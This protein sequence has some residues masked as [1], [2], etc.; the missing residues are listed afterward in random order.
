MVQG[1]QQ[2][3]R[4]PDVENADAD[5]EEGLED[6]FS[7]M[8]AE[9]SPPLTAARKLEAERGDESRATGSSREDA[10]VPPP[11]RISVHSVRPVPVPGAPEEM[12]Q[13][14][15]EKNSS[16]PLK[17]QD[18]SLPATLA[19]GMERELAR[20][21][22]ALLR[23]NAKLCAGD[24]GGREYFLEL[25]ELYRDN[26]ECHRW[27]DCVSDL[28]RNTSPELRVKA[29]AVLKHVA[30]CRDAVMAA[31]FLAANEM[32]V[33]G[34]TVALRAHLKWQ[35]DVMDPLLYDPAPIMGQ[36]LGGGHMP[37]GVDRSGN[38]IVLTCTHQWHARARVKGGDGVSA[39]DNFKRAACFVYVR[40]GGENLGRGGDGRGRESGGG[41][42][43]TSRS[44]E[45]GV[46]SRRGED[47]AGLWEG[48]IK[49]SFLLYV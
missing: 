27:A 41:G 38:P 22:P 20:V 6:L 28:P 10:E 44:E 49:G 29:S 37:C 12:S 34:A 19:E 35:R 13:P 2:S 36:L 16:L 23:L 21:G 31:R 45:R 5:T 8:F 9:E 46:G 39:T 40:K 11:L 14:P 47:V 43:I 42:R 15:V 4:I 32:S 24:V 3:P 18:R 25:I 48:R 30:P 26:A 7:M 17:K 1:I 33:E